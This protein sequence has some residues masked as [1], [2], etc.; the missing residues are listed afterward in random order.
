VAQR[1]Y[2]CRRCCEHLRSTRNGI[3]AALSCRELRV[4]V[5]GGARRH[6][7]AAPCFNSGTRLDVWYATLRK[8]HTSHK[9]TPTVT[10]SHTHTHTRIASLIALHSLSLIAAPHLPEPS[11]GNID[12]VGST[13]TDAAN[14]L[15]L[16]LRAHSVFWDEPGVIQEWVRDLPR[17]GGDNS[18]QKALWRRAQWY[19]DRYGSKVSC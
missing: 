2:D 12:Y 7:C 1:R 19:V 11:K 13:I 5:L 6:S 8:P 4:A 16:P 3:F 18:L 15:G 14:K 10:H 9:R 17:D